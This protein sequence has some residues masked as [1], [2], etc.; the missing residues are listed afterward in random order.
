M[1][2]TTTFEVRLK[3][4][5]NII[6]EYRIRYPS[7]FSRKRAMKIPGRYGFHAY[8]KSNYAGDGLQVEASPKFLFGQ[9][10][11]GSSDVKGQ[12]WNIVQGIKPA[13]GLG[14]EVNSAF[15]DILMRRIDLVVGLL[16]PLGIS[17][18]NALKQLYGVLHGLGRSL[19][20]YER[21]GRL[22]SLYVNPRGH[23][24]MLFYVKAN[25]IACSRYAMSPK[26]EHGD[27]FREWVS[28]VLRFE[29]RMDWRALKSDHRQLQKL[30]VWTPKLARELVS[31]AL[32]DLRVKGTGAVMKDF[33]ELDELPP[34]LKAIAL[35]HAMAAP[36]EASFEP[37]TY[38]RY[39]EELRELSN[40]DLYS[41]PGVYPG[42]SIESLINDPEFRFY[43]RP[44]WASGPYRDLLRNRG[45]H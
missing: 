3:N 24:R 28:R 26:I 21:Y 12:V 32:T 22:S 1:I 45:T 8:V 2:D 20:T 4:S 9:N 33:R 38:R 35:L 19:S 14:N 18:F 6:N 31:E 36:L 5:R 44:R 15:D 37:R 16:L 39:R 11:V 40:F 7:R 43:G 29:R 41:M 25:Q 10:I 42:L 30:A 13:L 17:P 27:R 34:R 23:K